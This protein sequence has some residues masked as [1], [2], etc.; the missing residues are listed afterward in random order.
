MC[1][2]DCQNAVR[3]SSKQILAL[4][5]VWLLLQESDSFV[6]ERSPFCLER[7]GPYD[8]SSNLFVI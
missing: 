1:Q 6:H 8:F 3:F 5:S 2:R 7:F 4:E